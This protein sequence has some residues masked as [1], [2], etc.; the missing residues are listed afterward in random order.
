MRP[1]LGAL[2]ATDKALFS[3][4]PTSSDES[5]IV[6]PSESL[7]RAN[8]AD[9][10]ASSP[11]KNLLSSSQ[12]QL[13]LAAITYSPGASF[14]RGNFSNNMA[15]FSSTG[16]ACRTERP[17]VRCGCGIAQNAVAVTVTVMGCSL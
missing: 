9:H 2:T 3:V 13:K 11:L 4:P 8:P 16:S 10:H 5:P 15:T 1:I 6:G 12:E 14:S 7:A 17:Q